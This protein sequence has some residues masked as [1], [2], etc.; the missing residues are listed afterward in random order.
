MPATL[1][2]KP[3]LT[4]TAM[5]SLRQPWN[6]KCSLMC[7]DPDASS[8]SCRRRQYLVHRCGF[9]TRSMRT[10]LDKLQTSK[11]HSSCAFRVHQC[12]PHQHTPMYKTYMHACCMRAV[13]PGIKNAMYVTVFHI[14]NDS[15]SPAAADDNRDEY[16][17]SKSIPS[18]SSISGSS[19]SSSSVSSSSL[20]VCVATDNPAH[21][22]CNEGLLQGAV[23]SCES[24]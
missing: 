16:H 23:V 1:M 6:R 3:S 7:A 18:S 10:T 13:T 8:T 9:C 5:M 20:C 15:N 2:S 17:N 12:Q 22:A 19:M 24:R 11:Q 21:Q 4:I 14:D